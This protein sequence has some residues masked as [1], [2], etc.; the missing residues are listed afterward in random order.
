M[1]HSKMQWNWIGPLNNM[2]RK[3][4]VD[5]KRVRIPPIVISSTTK[6]KMDAWRIQ[7]G[8]P[9]GRIV[10]A[11][12]EHVEHDHKFFLPLNGRRRSLML[13]FQP[14]SKQV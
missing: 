11:M 3:L 10:D 6:K 9:H 13:G 5:G 2:S 7:Y 1:K 12:F 8:I 14:F 4:Q